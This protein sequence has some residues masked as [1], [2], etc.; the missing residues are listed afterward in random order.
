MTNHECQ[1]RYR[2]CAGWV[3]TRFDGTRFI[4]VQ[5]NPPSDLEHAM[6]SAKQAGGWV[7]EDGKPAHLEKGTELGPKK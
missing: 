7:E 2:A 1:N 6:N 3:E 4:I 5:T